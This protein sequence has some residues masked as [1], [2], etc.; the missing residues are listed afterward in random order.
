MSSA[1]A[2]RPLVSVVIPTF[3]AAAFIGECLDSVYSQEAD[4]ELDVVLG[5]DDAVPVPADRV[6]THHRLNERVDAVL[7]V[8]GEELQH[9]VGIPFLPGTLEA[10]EQILPVAGRQVGGH[11]SILLGTRPT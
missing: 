2:Q 9:G 10:G 1:N 11:L 3:N 6:E 8:H 5:R 4:V 7:G